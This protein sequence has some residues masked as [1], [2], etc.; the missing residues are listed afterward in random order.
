MTDQPPSTETR[1]S[2]LPGILKL[3]FIVTVVL[4]A[5][6]AILRVTG[7]ISTEAFNDY[8]TTVLSVIVIGTVAAA[9]IAILTA[10]GKS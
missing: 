3:A 9:L 5:V 7:T 8:L 4:V 2:G 6:L 1:K 10:P